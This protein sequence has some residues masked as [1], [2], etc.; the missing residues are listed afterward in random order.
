VTPAEGGLVVEA[1]PPRTGWAHRRSRVT[2]DLADLA[3]RIAIGGLFLALAV[4]IGQN[5]METGHF[6][7]LLLLASE[8][9]VVVLTITRRPALQ[10]DRS[11]DARVITTLSILGPPLL[12]PTVDAGWLADAWTAP[13]SGVGLLIVIAGKV[14]LG[15]SFGVMPAH[16]GLVSSGPY[17]YV[18]HPIYLGYLVTHVAFLAAHPTAW[19]AVMLAVSDAALV[20]RAKYEERTLAG[21]P[22]YVGYRNR[23]RWRVIPG[24]Y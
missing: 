12:R 23:V 6:T 8:L 11:L 7:G 5:Y 1:G 19:N 20:V 4:R 9:L 3:A 13:I 21:D 2:G 16:R 24:L 15:R 14:S 17:R 22:E 10:V 18:R